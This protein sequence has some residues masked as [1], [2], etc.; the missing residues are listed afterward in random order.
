MLIK[1]LNIAEKIV[2]NNKD[3]RWIGWDIVSRKIT[4]QGFKDK[5][6]SFVDGKWGI[7][8]Q[9]PI[10]ENGWHLPNRYRSK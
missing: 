9:Y 3:L 7:D 8:T 1:D 5:N 4:N 6:G 2:R 10:T